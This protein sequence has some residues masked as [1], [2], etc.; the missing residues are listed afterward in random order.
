MALGA[1]RQPTAAAT[2]PNSARREKR[3][4]L[5]TVHSTARFERGAPGAC[6]AVRGFRSRRAAGTP[7]G[8]DG[9]AVEGARL[10]SVYRGNSIEGSNPSLSA[11]RISDLAPNGEQP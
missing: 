8:R 11:I 3:D 5:T 4:G 10:E 7:Q 2:D 1:R 6:Y 9:R